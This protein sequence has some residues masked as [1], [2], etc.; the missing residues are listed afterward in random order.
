MT[1]KEVAR[2][3]GRPRAYRAIGNVLNK[4]V[5]SRVPCHRVICSSGKVGGYRNGA[6]KKM[7]LLKS[8]RAL[9]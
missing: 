1:Y 6:R 4:N 3:I 7:E 9:S 5:D 2:A 8:E